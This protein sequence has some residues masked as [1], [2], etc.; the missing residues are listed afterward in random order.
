MPGGRWAETADEKEHT[1]VIRTTL[2]NLVAGAAT[3]KPLR[4]IHDNG[5]AARVTAGANQDTEENEKQECIDGP[6]RV[7]P[8]D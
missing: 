8:R 4:G 7:I 6:K 3:R 1:M 2:S 5:P